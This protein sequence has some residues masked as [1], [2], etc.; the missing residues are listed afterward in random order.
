MVISLLFSISGMPDTIAI[1]PMAFWSQEGQFLFLQLRGTEIR[2]DE[3]WL[4][5]CTNWFKQLTLPNLDQ[6]RLQITMSNM[7]KSESK[8]IKSNK[9]RFYSV[10]YIRNMYNIW[11]RIK[12]GVHVYFH[13]RLLLQ[14][15]VFSF[16]H[17]SFM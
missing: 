8:Y 9:L 12:S 16:V 5:Q 6:I 1:Y 2:L 14:I 15:E 7:K 4:L 10:R 11:Y 3:K 13:A 17:H